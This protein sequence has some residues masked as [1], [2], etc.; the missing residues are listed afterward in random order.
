MI[1]GNFPYVHFPVSLFPF[2]YICTK[3]CVCVCVCVGGGEIGK[4]G[5]LHEN[6]N[7]IS[8]GHKIN[9]SGPSG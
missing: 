9:G 2:P 3:V 5:M 7:T 4:E 6:D 8:L 1:L